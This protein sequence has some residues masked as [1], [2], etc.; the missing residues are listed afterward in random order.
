M[1]RGKLKTKR[2]KKTLVKSKQ[3]PPQPVVE[4]EDEEVV[5]SDHGEDLLSMVE[6]EDL[7]FLKQALDNSSYSLISEPNKFVFILTYFRIL[8]IENSLIGPVNKL[9]FK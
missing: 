1:R 7:E 8:G 4:D 9:G 3:P 6:K 2:H 5:E